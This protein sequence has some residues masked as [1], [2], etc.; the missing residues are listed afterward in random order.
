MRNSFVVLDVLIGGSTCIELNTISPFSFVANG[1]SSALL[2]M[3]KMMMMMSFRSFEE[4]DRFEALIC[5]GFKKMMMTRD[6]SLR[7]IVQN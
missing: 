7:R 5:I 4:R 1:N 2:F 6:F 3:R